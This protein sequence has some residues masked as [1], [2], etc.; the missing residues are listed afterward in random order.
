V[1]AAW[2]M[3]NV[4]TMGAPIVLSTQG[5]DVLYHGFS[6]GATGGSRGY[7]D[8]NDFVRLQLPPGLSEV[9]ADRYLRD[10]VAEFVRENTKAI[11]RLAFWK[12]VNMYRPFYADASVTNML[13][14]GGSYFGLVLLFAAGCMRTMRLG[15]PPPVFH[16]ALLFLATQVVQHALTIGMIRF[17]LPS[18]MVFIVLGAV[19]LTPVRLLR[20]HRQRMAEEGETRPVVSPTIGVLQI[21][22]RLNIG[23][24]AQHVVSLTE[25]FRSPPFRSHLIVGRPNLSE[26]DMMPHLDMARVR[27]TVVP[28]LGRELHP[29]SDVRA[30]LAIFRI[31]RRERPAIVHT[32]TAKAV[33]IGRTAALVHNFLLCFEEAGTRRRC[34]LVHTFH[35]HVLQGYF[36]G[37]KTRVYRWIERTLA[38]IT[39]RII[40]VSQAVGDDLLLLGVGTPQS[41]RVVK[42]G[43]PLERLLSLP[44]L[45]E[46][47]V[48]F[49]GSVG[50]LVPI[51]NHEMLPETEAMTLASC[52][53][54]AWWLVPLVYG[55]L[56]AAESV[57]LPG[58]DLGLRRFQTPPLGSEMRL[59]QTFLMTG[60]GLDAIEVFP[61]AAGKGVSGDIRFELHE[62][63]E[64]GSDH[65]VTRLRVLEVLAE[66][67]VRAPSYV[68]AFPAIADSRDRTYRFDL[69]AAPADSVALWATKGRRYAGGGLHAN[70]RE[71]WADLAFRVH[72]PAPTVWGRLMTLRETHPAR[73]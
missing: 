50:R 36:V 68:F 1:L 3:R 45:T 73:A 58:Y 44:P 46:Q 18:E 20:E 54:A 31:I 28:S 12:L 38:R 55:L 34:R 13:V 59:A 42:L 14:L 27:C 60:D 9:E 7:V 17:R 8:D 72:A 40:V 71:R 11:P 61:V 57:T 39:D 43:I 23:G 15:S 16:L 66:D 37:R 52:R 33:A 63:H 32:H 24:T 67:L 41:V 51:K 70:G 48:T 26:G 49:I 25:G 30:W 22:T 65:R 21:I 69:V 19:P 2:T 29:I 35:G 64:V 5:G 6:P 53:R 56:L 47:P 4:L 10:A 62:I